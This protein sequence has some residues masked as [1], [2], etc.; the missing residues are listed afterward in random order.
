MGDVK[1]VS[2]NGAHLAVRIDG[3]A[4]KPWMVLSNSLACTLE[5]WRFQ[6]PLLTRTHRVLRYDTR[7][8]GAS[9]AP[10]GPYSMDTFVDDMVGLMDHFGIGRADLIGLSL[11]G[12]TAIGLAIRAPERV[13]RLISIAA[14]TDTNPAF[15]ENWD[16]RCAAVRAAGGM[17]GVADFTLA[18]W[19]TPAFHAAHPEVVREAKEMILGCDMDG[20]IACAD[21]LRGLDYKRHLG[22]IRAPALFIAGREDGGAPPAEIQSMAALTPGARFA[23][24]EAAHIVPMENPGAFNAQVE[25]FLAE[26]PVPAG[27]VASG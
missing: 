6:M 16:V 15:L 20:Y 17:S 27:D 19:F 14:R 22:A 9:S 12:M 7:A 2:V 8:H 21:A 25:S 3:D 23:V 11:G 4:D 26:T 13:A 18:R 24:I 5:S 10:A 1:M